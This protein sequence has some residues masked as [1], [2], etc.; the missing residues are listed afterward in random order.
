M[1]A[2]VEH[3][4]VDY[5][6]VPTS[7]IA[8]FPVLLLLLLGLRLATLRPKSERRPGLPIG[9]TIRYNTPREV[10]YAHFRAGL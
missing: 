4:G 6:Q 2:T 9:T 10:T 1:P 8:E 5:P 3:V 7:A